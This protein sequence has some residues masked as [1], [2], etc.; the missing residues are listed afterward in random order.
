MKQTTQCKW[1]PA[2]LNR[3]LGGRCGKHVMSPSYS[4]LVVLP[5][6][7]PL[8]TYQYAIPQARELG[9]GEMI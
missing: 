7:S 1:E 6:V 5:Y 2:P 8:Q 3:R 4:E 9:K